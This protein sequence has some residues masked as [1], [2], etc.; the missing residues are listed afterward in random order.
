M[1][2]EKKSDQKVH[3][4]EQSRRR[5]L[6]QLEDSESSQQQQKEISQSPDFGG[7]KKAPKELAEASLDDLLASMDDAP[8]LRAKDDLMEQ[9]EGIDEADDDEE[10]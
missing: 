1:G 7:R 10:D 6:L 8:I 5:D 4:Q 2:Q 3:F 9:L